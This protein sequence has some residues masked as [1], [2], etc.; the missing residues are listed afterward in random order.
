MLTGRIL[1]TLCRFLSK[2]TQRKTLKGIT[3]QYTTIKTNKSMT[4]D[5]ELECAVIEMERMRACRELPKR[6]PNI[7]AVDGKRIL[8]C[9]VQ[10]RIDAYKE[11]GIKK[12][13]TEIVAGCGITAPTY[14]NLLEKYNSVYKQCKKF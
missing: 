10:A 7:A 9:I 1:V 4:N 11:Q 2:V 6:V 13:L 8:F 12:P 3:N 14:Y 5:Y